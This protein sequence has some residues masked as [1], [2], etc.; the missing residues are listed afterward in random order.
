MLFPSLSMD[1]STAEEEPH[2]GPHSLMQGVRVP[3]WSKLG[4]HCLLTYLILGVQRQSRTVLVLTRLS[5]FLFHTVRLFSSTADH[6]KESR[7]YHSV[8]MSLEVSHTHRRSSVSCSWWHTCVPVFPPQIHAHQWLYHPRTYG[9]SMYLKTSVYRVKR[10]G[11]KTVPSGRRSD[12]TDHPGTSTTTKPMII[13]T[14]SKYVVC[15]SWFGS[16]T[17]T[18]HNT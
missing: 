18:T 15:K 4:L 8:R 14:W 16:I 13:Y 10:K 7:S 1:E 12:E 5:L 3:D 9:C 17:L 2:R 11:E 6:Y